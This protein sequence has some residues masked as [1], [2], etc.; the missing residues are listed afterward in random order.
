MTSQDQ[1]GRSRLNTTNE[2]VQGNGSTMGQRTNDMPPFASLYS[3]IAY[4]HERI[5][6]ISKK[7]PDHQR[8]SDYPSMKDVSTQTNSQHRH[9]VNGNTDS[10]DFSAHPHKHSQQPK[11]NLDNPYGTPHINPILPCHFCAGSGLDLSQFPAWRWIN[12]GVPAVAPFHPKMT[13]QHPTRSSTT[14]DGNDNA[15]HISWAFVDTGENN[16]SKVSYIYLELSS[17]PLE[18]RETQNLVHQV[19]TPRSVN[20]SEYPFNRPKTNTQYDGRNSKASCSESELDI[21]EEL[22]SEVPETDSETDGGN[23]M[24]L[25]KVSLTQ[26]RASVTQ[27]RNNV[28]QKRSRHR[29]FSYATSLDFADGEESMTGSADQEGEI[30]PFVAFVSNLDN[31]QPPPKTNKEPKRNLRSNVRNRRPTPGPSGSDSYLQNS[32][33][34]DNEAADDVT[35]DKVDHVEEEEIDIDLEDPEVQMAALKMQAAFKGFSARKK[36]G[37]IKKDKPKTENK[38]PVKAIKPQSKIPESE[39]FDIDMDDPEVEQAALKMQAAFKG[40]SMRK[41]LGKAKPKPRSEDKIVPKE[42]PQENTSMNTTPRNVDTDRELIDFDL[43]DPEV[44]ATTMQVQQ[45]SLGKM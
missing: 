15:R 10:C 27:N 1:E 40:F 20:H 28:T 11:A 44:Q 6:K 17:S 22:S 2:S 26:N 16:S 19:S 4:L 7:I 32:F 43:N 25:K 8:Q 9:G 14:N 31:P 18:S 33:D 36:M 35:R 3:E 38:D 21:L 39:E 30:S 45:T 34:F 23:Y 37:L 42:A 13:Q 41:K 12:G 29:Q 24:L 5:D